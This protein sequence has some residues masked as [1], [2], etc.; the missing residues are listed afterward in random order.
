MD[1][2]KKTMLGQLV[3]MIDSFN[4]ITKG[5]LRDICGPLKDLVAKLSGDDWK[6][7]LD[8]L[9]KFLRGEALGPMA[10]RGELGPYLR[11]ICPDDLVLGPTDG[12]QTIS[13][14]RGV[15]K[16]GID[17][18]FEN[19]GWDTKSTPTPM[20][21][22]RVF[23]L[24]TSG[25]FQ[26]IFGN[27][28]W[29]KVAFTQPQVINF[30]VKHERWLRS[31]GNGNFFLVKVKLDEGKATEREEY[32]VEDVR[33]RCGGWYAHGYRLSFERVRDVG[34]HEFFV[35]PTTGAVSSGLI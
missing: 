25:T 29:G 23:E 34:H 16:S 26:Q 21:T 22:A 17:P 32:F 2:R 13:S 12:S 24:R 31:D 9:K 27:G 1:K 35:L 3:V 14:V 30:V 28:D 7:W 8:R 18:I 4:I 11:L 15:F 20:I 6:M 10:S 5:A 19:L 33:W